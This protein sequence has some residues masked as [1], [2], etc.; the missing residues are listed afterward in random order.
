MLT[1]VEIDDNWTDCACRIYRVKPSD[2]YFE[3]FTEI[4]KAEGKQVQHHVNSCTTI[5]GRRTPKEWEGCGGSVI[6]YTTRYRDGLLR[7]YEVST[8]WISRR[9]TPTLQEPIESRWRE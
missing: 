3:V 8:D 4:D 5:E 9:P 1:P 6:H 7:D 2:P